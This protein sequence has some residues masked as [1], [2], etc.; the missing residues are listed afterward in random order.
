MIVNE[1]GSTNRGPRSCPRC[2]TWMSQN[3]D[4]YS[5]EIEYKCSGCGHSEK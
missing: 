4:I 3:F 2:D 5:G 1:Y